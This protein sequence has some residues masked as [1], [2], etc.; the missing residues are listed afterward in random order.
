MERQQG[1]G[2]A[3]MDFWDS[4]INLIPSLPEFSRIES[5]CIK[6][7]FSQKILMLLLLYLK[8]NFIET[9]RLI[10]SLLRF[11]K[12]NCFSSFKLYMTGRKRFT[13]LKWIFMNSVQ[14]FEASLLSE[15]YLNFHRIFPSTVN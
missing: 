2:L 15:L 8:M 5:N 12:L 6:W 11:S 3:L 9:F 13:Q 10:P 4:S 14:K 7:D 1:L